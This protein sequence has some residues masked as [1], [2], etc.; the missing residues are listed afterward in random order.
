MTANA[1]VVA[2]RSDVIAAT[3]RARHAR[4]AALAALLGRAVRTLGRALR[5]HQAPP[6]RTAAA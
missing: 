6:P 4:D 2:V 3:L 1:A 5:G